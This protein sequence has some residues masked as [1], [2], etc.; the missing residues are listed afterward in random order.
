MPHIDWTISIG[1][2]LYGTATIIT[3][4][5]AWVNL[6]WRVKNIEDW[7]AEHFH[8]TKE[9]EDN[10][11]LMRDNVVKL[12]AMLEGQDRRLVLVED[13]QEQYRRAN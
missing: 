1:S 10:I 8:S 9:M 6:H 2:L 12:T 4:V 3:F 13:R 7:R 5:V 11:R